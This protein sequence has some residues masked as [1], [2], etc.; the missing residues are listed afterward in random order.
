MLITGHPE[1]LDRIDRIVLMGG[2]VGLGNVT[3]AA[4]FNIYV[5]PEA[6]SI[7]FGSGVAVEM[8]GLDVTHQARLNSSHA[9]RLRGA[10]DAG[11]FVAALLD[12]FLPNYQRRMGF[13][14][15]PIHD[16]LAV[17]SVID[18]DLVTMETVAIEID[19]SDGPSVGRT[20]V[21]RYHVTGKPANASVGIEVQ[22]DRFAQLLIDRISSLG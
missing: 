12:F 6:A 16:A 19:T 17:A 3:P 22:S 14:G 11:A 10:G 9:E 13:D 20:L 18:P 15:A 4:E 21:D 7:V 1:L 5:D 8:V 2:A